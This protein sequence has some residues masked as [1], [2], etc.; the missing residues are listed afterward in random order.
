MLHQEKSQKGKVP[1]QQQCCC[2]SR[3]CDSTHEAV[4]HHKRRSVERATTDT[5]SFSIK[6]TLYFLLMLLS[7][8]I[9]YILIWPRMFS[10]TGNVEEKIVPQ[11]LNPLSKFSSFLHSF[12][13][14]H[15]MFFCTFFETLRLLGTSN[16]K[17]M[18][19]PVRHFS[20]FFY[21]PAKEHD[22]GWHKTRCINLLLLFSLSFHKLRFEEFPRH[23]TRK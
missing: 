20:R 7:N 11:Q 8:R 16:R 14:F 23:F 1:Q 18:C 6:K 10:I 17:E 5:K 9:H 15:F 21:E 3:C 12:V 19:G 4:A 22:I 13:S 2:C